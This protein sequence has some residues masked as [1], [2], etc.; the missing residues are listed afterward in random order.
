MQFRCANSE[1]L[2][3]VFLAIKHGS[4][5]MLKTNASVGKE[6]SSGSIIVTASGACIYA[7]SFLLPSNVGVTV[8]GIRSG[9]GPIDCAQEIFP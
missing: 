9:A 6:D 5:A 7:H 1:L 4:L 2:Y 3:S 8:A